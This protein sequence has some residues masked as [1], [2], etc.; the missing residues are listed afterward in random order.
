MNG[1]MVMDGGFST[2]MSSKI[3]L[4][5]RLGHLICIVSHCWKAPN[6]AP[7]TL[8]FLGKFVRVW[9]SSL[10]AYATASSR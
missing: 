7:L 9:P 10:R 5:A 4:D 6:K 1:W 8:L 3:A 2:R